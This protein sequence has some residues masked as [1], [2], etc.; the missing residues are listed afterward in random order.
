MGSK[1]L[2]DVL[3]LEK[4]ALVELVLCMFTLLQHLRKIVNRR[5]VNCNT[6]IRVLYTCTN[7]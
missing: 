4:R 5:D 7:D 3:Q 1:V 2:S 6:M